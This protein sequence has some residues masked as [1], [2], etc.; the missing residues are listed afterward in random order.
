MWSTKG[1]ALVEVNLGNVEELSFRDPQQSHTIREEESRGSR[2]G[3]LICH[4]GEHRTYEAILVAYTGV[5]L[6]KRTIYYYSYNI[7]T[8]TTVV[9]VV[10]I[11]LYY[12]SRVCDVLIPQQSRTT[13]VLPLIFVQLL[14]TGTESISSTHWPVHATNHA[15]FHCWWTPTR[16]TCSIK[17]I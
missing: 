3:E 4:R 1:A 12:S 13:H 6:R 5:F 11:I 8:T 10:L 16:R 7:Y 14:Q 9:P 2:G 15:V 17:L